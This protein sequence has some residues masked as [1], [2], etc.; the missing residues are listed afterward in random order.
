M[1]CSLQEFKERAEA[2][3]GL[4]VTLRA[5]GRL[6]TS[7]KVGIVG[8]DSSEEGQR[9]ETRNYIPVNL[10]LSIWGKTPHLE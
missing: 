2:T 9:K 5:C 4:G 3:V 1:V 7:G 8:S 10:G 6:G